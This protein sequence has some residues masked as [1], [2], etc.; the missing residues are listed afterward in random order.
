MVIVYVEKHG[1]G[2]AVERFSGYGIFDLLPLST[3]FFR[4]FFLSTI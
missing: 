3:S 4:L 1:E 2:R